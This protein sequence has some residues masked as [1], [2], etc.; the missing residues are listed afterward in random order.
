MDDAKEGAAPGEQTPQGAGGAGL[1]RRRRRQQFYRRRE[2]R[3]RRA[4]AG[5]IS[6][7]GAH[8]GAGVSGPTAARPS[9]PNPTRHNLPSFSPFQILAWVM[10]VGD[11]NSH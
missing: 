1:A 9:R 8:D 3:A 7:R 11:C 2:R 6:F 10:V 4:G 5:L